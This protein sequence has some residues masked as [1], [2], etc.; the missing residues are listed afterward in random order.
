MR[1]YMKKK[2]ERVQRTLV[3]ILLALLLSS[4]GSS[5]SGQ[6]PAPSAFAPETLRQWLTV[7]SSDEFEGR[8]TFSAGL[9]RAAYYIADRLKE[10]GVKPGGENGSYFQPVAVETIEVVNQSTMTVEV[11]GESR[12][13]KNG[14][15][16]FFSS[17]VGGKRTFT[18]SG[19]EFVGYGLNL[20]SEHNDYDGREF[21]TRPWCG[22]VMRCPHP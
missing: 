6:A 10:A 16:V 11:H 12:T 22:S 9:D 8:A 3:G 17:N 21:E 1:E 2:A 5:V 19:A 14:E 13:F 7:L 15:G 4:C 18:V 20:G